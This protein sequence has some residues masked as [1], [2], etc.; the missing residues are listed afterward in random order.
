M[1]SKFFYNSQ[2]RN[3]TIAFGSLFNSIYV[4]RE[5]SEGNPISKEK[6]SITYSNKSKF[7]QRNENDRE[8][9][10][11][12]SI[13]LPRIAFNIVGLSYA[14]ERKS[15]T[16]RKVITGTGTDNKNYV[17]APIPYDINFAMSIMTKT[18]TEAFQIIEQILPFFDPEYSLTIKA[19]NN[20]ISYD[21]PISLIGLNF[22]DTF[23]GSFDES[24]TIVWDLDFILKGLIYGPE[25]SSSIIKQTINPIHDLDTGDF[26]ERL[27]I[28]PYIDGVPL[29]E[30]SKDDD[31]EIQITVDDQNN[32]E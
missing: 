28:E 16:K 21:I 17:Y 32:D 31:Y 8:H 30:I 3:F 14:A 19:V 20:S 22:D 25:R 6:V 27:T 1:Y 15:S 13:V 24:R 7:F 12:P 18:Q 11:K 23:D 4:Q 10:R 26:I 29:S 5:D 9:K 2:I